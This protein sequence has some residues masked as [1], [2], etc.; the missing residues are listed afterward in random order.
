MRPIRPAIR[1]ALVTAAAAATAVA[2]L[3]APAPA[4]PAN[5]VLNGGFE[6]GTTASWT[7]WPAGGATVAA[8]GSFEGAHHAVL[9]A[10]A[11]LAQTVQG[12]ASGQDYLATGRYRSDDAESFFVGLRYFDASHPGVVEAE[13]SYA[14]SA[15]WTRFG[16][17]FTTGDGRTQVGLLAQNAGTGSGHLD[18]VRLYELSGARSDIQDLSLEA[19]TIPD[20][21]SA[22]WDSLQ[23]ALA[24]ADAAYWDFGLPDA[25]VAAAAAALEDAVRAFDPPPPDGIASPG[26][27][28]YYVSSSEG[29]D[30]NDGLSPETPW[31]SLEKLNASTFAAGDEILLKAGDSWEGTVLHPRGSGEEGAPITLGKYG[32]EDRPYLNAQDASVEMDTYNLV[33]G[34]DSHLEPYTQEFYTTVYLADQEHWTIRDLE[35]AN[36]AAGWTDLNGDAKLRSGI[37]VMND[38]A[39]TLSGIQVLDNEVHHVLGDKAAKTYWGGAG[40]VFTVML[41]S[42][43]AAVPSNYDG[44]LVEGNY[45]HDTNRQGIVTNSR[46]NLRPDID[47]LGDLADAV[48]KGL[49]PWYPSTDVV[50]RDNYVADVA[51][52][53]ILPQ[54]TQ[55]ALVERN[56]VD[57]FNLRSGGASAGIWAW[58]ADDT[59]FQFNEAFG[60][61]TTHDGQG[62]DVDYGQ[63]GTIYQ[64][65]YSHDNDGGFILFCSPGQG[66]DPESPGGGVRSQDAVVRYNIS[67]NDRARSFMFSGY[68]DGALIYNNTVYQ[69]PGINARPVDFWAWNDTYPTSASFYNNVF[70]LDS[71]GPW[72]FQDQGLSMQG[73]VFDSN[74]IYGVHSAGEPADPNKSTEDPLLAAPGTGTTNTPVG[75]SYER[76]SLDGY[77]LQEGSPAIGTGVIVETAD[78]TVIGGLAPNGGRDYWGNPVVPG[79]PPTRGAWSAERDRGGNG[80]GNHCGRGNPNHC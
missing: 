42:P 56:T 5:L 16:I 23:T 31:E 51:G 67:Q 43:D 22:A 64:Y 32:G 72:N 41:K 45:V 48:E 54:V 78:G 68:S 1:R 55:G 2:A 77:A 34:E 74:T 76:P 14:E 49:S 70:H 46:Q 8:T 75:G 7:P 65:N 58:N 30:G 25:D 69:G 60:G 79:V 57:G 21:G 4:A 47:H 17:P 3:A 26:D 10:G 36:H 9:P 73:V 80:H 53:G 59:V 13:K 40:I 39:G 37:M 63:T 38:N 11:S 18:D 6:T 29:D 50:I 44:L 52:D 12:L 71:A 62:Y 66:S 61:H 20:D 15:E 28:A 24:E 19:A 33:K 35:V 27:T